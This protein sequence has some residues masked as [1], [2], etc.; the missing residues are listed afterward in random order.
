MKGC[1]HYLIEYQHHKKELHNAVDC[2]CFHLLK[3]SLLLESDARHPN[4]SQLF[5]FKL[6]RSTDKVL[7]LSV[8][9]VYCTNDTGQDVEMHLEST[10]FVIPKNANGMVPANDQRIY[11][12]NLVNLGLNIQHY[13]GLEESILN[14]RSFSVDACTYPNEIFLPTDP[15]IVFMC[16]YRSKLPWI[17]VDD[18]VQ[19][20]NGTHYRV[21]KECLDKT[22]TF[23]QEAIFPLFHYVRTNSLNLTWKKQIEP[24][25]DEE[26]KRN[27]GFA[28]IVCYFR[29]DY[30][31][32]TEEM[33]KI[34]IKQ[35]RLL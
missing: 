14:A 1:H 25:E 9:L 35:T 2:V 27:D 17:R 5:D 10:R 7:I 22:R 24:K 33:P 8:D 16:Q 12:P 29:I 30:I 20:K 19:V 26:R 28:M 13:A 15:L 3:D 4:G 32:L 31:L 34:S 11:E 21:N 23:F 18:I 6:K